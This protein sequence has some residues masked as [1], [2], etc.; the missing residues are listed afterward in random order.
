MP[1]NINWM[2]LQEYEEQDMTAGSQDLACSAGSC[3][4]VDLVSLDG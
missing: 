1:K 3:E 2:K 4:I